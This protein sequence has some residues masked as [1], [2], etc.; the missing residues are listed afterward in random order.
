MGFKRENQ[1]NNFL[2]VTV[3]KGSYVSDNFSNHLLK[4]QIPNIVNLGLNAYINQINISFPIGPAS[5]LTNST[6]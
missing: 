4:L 5:K 6:M 3:P 1:H 2:I